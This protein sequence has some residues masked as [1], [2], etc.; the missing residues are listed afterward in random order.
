MSIIKPTRRGLLQGIGGLSGLGMLGG[1][2]LPARALPSGRRLVVVRALGGW[3]TT[4]CMDPR[5]STSVSG[6]LVV[7]GPDVDEA[8]P[9]DEEIVPYGGLEIMTNIGKRPAVDRFF[10]AHANDTVVVNGIYT[11]SIVHD[12]CRVRILT[13]T[14][15]T[16]NPDVGLIA[17]LGGADTFAIPY[18]DLTGGAFLG[19]YAAYAGQLGLNN[20]IKALLDRTIPL[21]GAEGSGVTYPNYLPS[22]GQA[23]A[24]A[25]F[26]DDR[27][28]RLE[29]KGW[30]GS[31]SQKRIDDLTTASERR[32]RLLTEGQS[33]S[34]SLSFGFTPT[35][36]EQAGLAVEMLESGLCHSV[37]IEDTTSWDSH[38]DISDQHGHF[39]RLFGGLEVLV[40]A[41]ELAGLFNDTLIVVLSE[42]TRTPLRNQDGGKDHWSS[43]SALLIGGFLEGARSLGGT[44]T[45]MVPYGID[46]PTGM[47]DT[48]GIS[49]Q[50][51]QFIGG[52]MRA[53]G[54]DTE[55]WFPGL[56][57]LRGIVD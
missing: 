9:G 20:Q 46:L 32:D 43:T 24:I 39:E 48:A 54:V 19:A 22:N 40:D 2:S 30:A 3:D 56:E 47:I 6:Q 14:R 23:D 45:G 33:L 49:L 36:N 31:R 41:L 10:D 38:N 51:D 15:S 12:E 16:S 7:E 5:L 4:F 25:A 34:D 37:A 26:V 29:S 50:F 28:N 8:S 18:L 53:A 21:Q 52:V 44:D 57:V 55:E 13:G 27:T 35:L 11:G 42:M 1:V 17:S